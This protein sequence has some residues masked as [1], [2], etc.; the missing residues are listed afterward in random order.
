MNRNK[1]ILLFFLFLIGSVSS[2]PNILLLNLTSNTS[3]AAL[4]PLLNQNTTLKN[5][6]INLTL[7]PNLDMNSQFV[8]LFN[9][10]LSNKTIYSEIITNL[11]NIIAFKWTQTM[12]Q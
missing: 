8:P 7:N 11:S 6:V 3:L 5:A 4:S 10:I 9:Y 12:S 2:Q 1:L